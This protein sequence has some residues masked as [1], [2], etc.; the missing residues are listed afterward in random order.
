MELDG[1]RVVHSG[2]DRAADDLNAIVGRIEARLQDLD[3]DLG[4]LRSAWVGDAQ[5]SY[6]GAKLRW[7]T[8]VGEMRDLLCQASL[9]VAQSNSSYRG[10]DAR[11]ARAF[12]L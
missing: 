9:Q 8:A 2:L 10:A 12:D 6:R 5:E 4:P 11:G 1:L 3:H 7:D